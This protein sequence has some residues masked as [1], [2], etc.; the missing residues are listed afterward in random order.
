[1]AEYFMGQ[2]L[3]QAELPANSPRPPETP[4]EGIIMTDTRPDGSSRRYLYI[5]MAGEMPEEITISETG[6]TKKP[7]IS[8]VASP[9]LDEPAPRMMEVPDGIEMPDHALF[10]ENAVFSGIPTA[11]VSPY[12]NRGTAPVMG[13]PLQESRQPIRM[14]GALPTT[15]APF[16]TMS[17]QNPATQTPVVVQPA[18]GPV[19]GGQVHIPAVPNPVQEAR[20]MSGNIKLSNSIETIRPVVAAP[21]AEAPPMSMSAIQDRQSLGHSRSLPLTVQ[22]GR[23]SDLIPIANP[24]NQNVPIGAGVGPIGGPSGFVQN[25][26]PLRQLGQAAP[27]AQPAAAGT[28]PLVNKC[29][30]AVEMPDGRVIEP[31]DGISLQDLCELVPFLIE[32]LTNLQA[33]GL[34]PGQKVPLVG[35]TPGAPAVPAPGSFGPAGGVNGPFGR[36]G[37]PG[38]FV[39]GGGG[40]PGPAG[41][42]GVAGTMGVPGPGSITEPPV[43][44]TDGDFVAGP[45][46]FVP[47]PGTALVWSQ[48]TPGVAKVHVLVTLGTSLGADSLLS[49]NSQIGLRIDGTDYSCHTRLMHSFSGGVGEFMVGQSFTF[50]IVLGAGSHSVELLLRGLLPGEYGAGL[51]FSASVAAV[52][53]VP[54]MITVSH[55]V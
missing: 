50:P 6:P 8:G 7:R 23:K 42:Q 47:V 44:K 25:Q 29:P 43:I 4:P 5:A 3:I 52:P 13:T 17:L 38:G 1:M 46:A 35:Q 37:A 14:N 22:E 18:Q 51:G 16:A 41:P 2:E 20:E 30:G 19:V 34:A 32:T 54:L 49:E 24:I 53:T 21:I 36:G 15:P 40:G 12:V 10:P 28:K 39:G 55:S 27:A 45:G 31:G 26:V 33:Q 9:V 11:P 48:S